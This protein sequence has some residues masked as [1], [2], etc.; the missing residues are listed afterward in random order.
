MTALIAL[1]GVGMTLWWNERKER[2]ALK[3]SRLDEYRREARTIVAQIA[4]GVTSHDLIA[5]SLVEF[6]T[7]PDVIHDD[8]VRLTGEYNESLVELRQKI[9]LAALTCLDEGLHETLARLGRLLLVLHLRLGRLLVAGQ[10]AE[11]GEQSIRF[12][13]KLAS[14]DLLLCSAELQQKAYRVLLPTVLEEA[15]HKRRNLTRDFSRF[16]PLIR[17]GTTERNEADPMVRSGQKVND[18]SSTENSPTE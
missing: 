7:N 11:M 10:V 14:R 3:L 4:G 15:A 6:A 18:P 12:Q 9:V 1:A 17:Y 5:S 16:Y 8:V 13:I 2:R